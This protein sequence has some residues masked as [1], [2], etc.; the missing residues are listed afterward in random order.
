MTPDYT[1][2]T[3]GLDIH[4]LDYGGDKPPLVLLHSLSA[5]SRVFHGLIVNGLQNHFR[6]IIPDMRGR[7]NSGNPPAGYSLDQHADDLCLL[8]DHLVITK[9]IVAG[10]SFG[11]YGAAWFAS[12]YPG[13]ISG[14]AFLDSAISLNPATPFLVQSS[15]CRLFKVYDSWETFLG[16]V[17]AAP[18]MNRWDAAM[19]P[20]FK[21]DILVHENGMVTPRSSWINILQAAA[22]LTSVDAATWRRVFASVRVPVLMLTASEPFMV[23]QY[24]L[25]PE[26][27]AETIAVVPASSDYEVEGN[28]FTML[29]GNGASQTVNLLRHFRDAAA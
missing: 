25:T 8:L 12:K 17:R 7:G 6:V 21:E 11:G 24:I 1:L 23:G 26:N 15:L 14:V 4:Y 19:L 9:T 29:F 20:F 16:L 10:H 28:H 13:R 27:V 3:P 18:F 22:H 2:Q 5:N